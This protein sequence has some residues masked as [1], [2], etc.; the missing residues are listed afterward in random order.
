MF[1]SDIANVSDQLE[2]ISDVAKNIK[3]I[4]KTLRENIEDNFG[5]EARK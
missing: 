3:K 4:D 1:P 5:E 2:K